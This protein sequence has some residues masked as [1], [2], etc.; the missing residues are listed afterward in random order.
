MC[1]CLFKRSSVRTPCVN[2]R[3]PK[4]VSACPDSGSDTNREVCICSVCMCVTVSH[5]YSVGVCGVPR[6]LAKF[7]H[8]YVSE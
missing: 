2:G 8:K 1:W 4:L 7:S 6:P 5:T 3:L